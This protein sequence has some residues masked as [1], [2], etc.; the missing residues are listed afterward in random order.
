MF[1]N[2]GIGALCFTVRDLARTETFYRDVLGLEP[3][4]IDGDEGTFVL[5]QTG[6]TF[7][8]AFKGEDLPGKSPIVVFSLPEG[9]IDDIYERLVGLGVPFVLPVSPAPDG[10]LTADFLDPDQHLFSLHQD[11]GLPRN[12]VKT[13]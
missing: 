2:S 4:R 13:L 9:G 10:G 11:A 7:L 8:I 1:K 12:R 5:A 3:S 6:S